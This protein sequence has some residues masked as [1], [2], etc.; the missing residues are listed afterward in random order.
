MEMQRKP[1]G[2]SANG[3]DSGNARIVNVAL[4]KPYEGVGNA[5]RSTF[6]PGRDALPDDMMALLSKLDTH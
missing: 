6:S 2:R 3:H 4:P 1:F 5:L